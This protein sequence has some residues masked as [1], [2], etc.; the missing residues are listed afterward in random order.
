MFKAK[1]LLFTFMMLILFSAKSFS[2]DSWQ[3]PKPLEVKIFDA[4]VGEWEG[5]SPS[6]MGGMK[7][8]QSAKVY[9]TL[10]KQF[11]VMEATSIAV[12]NP[13]MKYNGIGYYTID[14]N[15]KVKSWWFDNWGAEMT[16]T[17]TGEVTDTKLVSN[18]TSAYGTDNRVFEL[19]GNE[20]TMTGTMTWTENGKEMKMEDK[21]VFKKK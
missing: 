16:M 18:S 17:G 9:W 14:K 4:F 21:T 3:P 7:F 15:G 8:N 13:Q 12:D 2:Q 6:D 5:V 11:L 19:N 10:N 1:L 20:L